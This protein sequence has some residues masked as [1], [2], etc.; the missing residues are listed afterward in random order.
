MPRPAPM[1][2]TT[3]QYSMFT[4]RAVGFFMKNIEPNSITSGENWTIM[5]ST[6]RPMRPSGPMANS[7]CCTAGTLPVT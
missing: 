5:P 4:P 7:I 1:V 6:V 3:A 2:A